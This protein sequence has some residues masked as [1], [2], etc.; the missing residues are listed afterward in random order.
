MALNIVDILK[1]AV[2]S[3]AADVFIVAGTNACARINGEI[4]LLTEERLMPDDTLHLVSGIYR[5]AGGRSMADYEKSGDD[6]FSFAIA[7]LS[8]FRVSAYMQRGSCAATI[9]VISFELPDPE[10]LGRSDQAR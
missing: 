5:M 9:R 6:D 4:R 8:R 3:G 1:R 7:G 10:Q 2:D